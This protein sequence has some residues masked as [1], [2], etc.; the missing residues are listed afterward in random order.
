[1]PTSTF[2]NNFQSSMEQQLIEDL[3]T[4]S[5]RIYGMDVYYLPRTV[6][7][8]DDIF[9]EDDMSEYNAAILMEMYVKNVDGFGGDGDFLS[10]FNL[11]VRDT[12]TF[13]ISRR[14]FYEE[15]A[16]SYSNQSKDAARPR[17]GDLVYFPLNRKLFKIT[18]VEHE[19]IF[20]Q[21]GS[22][23]MWDLRCELFEY[24]DERLSTGIEEVD[25]IEWEVAISAD[26]LAI[27]THNREFIVDE[28][29]SSILQAAYSEGST[30]PGVDLDPL[31]QNQEIE[32]VADG[33]IDFSQIDPFSEGEY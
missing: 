27:L 8:R 14:S 9:Q 28:N 3:V 18:F 1:M 32:Q 16:P 25:R 31:A 30:D 7:S 19:A 13:S 15:M 24:S 11:Q 5:I 22:L 33:I 10:K 21:M 29:G 23:Q 20:Y 4:E 2:F 12:I 26:P 6:V 17:E